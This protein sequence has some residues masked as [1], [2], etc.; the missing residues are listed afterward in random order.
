MATPEWSILHTRRTHA[1]NV[2]RKTAWSQL[3]LFTVERS[4]S[5]LV[6]GAVKGKGVL[7]RNLFT[8]TSSPTEHF[9][10]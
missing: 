6:F 5:T 9:P 8:R 4:F 7:A 10:Q 3:V 2:A 1:Q